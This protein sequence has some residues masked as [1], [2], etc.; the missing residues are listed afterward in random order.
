MLPRLKYNCL[1]IC[2]GRCGLTILRGLVRMPL[3]GPQAAWGIA[4]RSSNA[5]I[6]TPPQTVMS[7]ILK[8]E[9]AK[10]LLEKHPT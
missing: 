1:G 10:A 2:V 6:K 3:G 9:H 5:E 7:G 8:Q 4:Y